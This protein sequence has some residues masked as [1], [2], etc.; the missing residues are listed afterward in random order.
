MK[1]IKFALVGVMGFAFDAAFFYLLIV[2]NVEPML[3]RVLA[4]W[5]AASCT[6]L[7]NKYLTFACKVNSGLLKQWGKHM[8]S[9]HASGIA[10]LSLFYLLS[11]QVALPIAFTCGIAVGAIFNY[12]LSTKYV[13][14]KATL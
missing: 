13:F 5:L 11:S 12:W 2:A 7:G 3:A 9:A 10:N 14:T 1:V 6:W 8:L 4:F